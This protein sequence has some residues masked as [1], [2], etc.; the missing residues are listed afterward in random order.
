MRTTYQLRSGKRQ[1]GAREAWSADD[2]V[3]DYVRALGCPHD[4]IVCLGAGAVSWRGA[5]YRAEPA[6][7]ESIESRQLVGTR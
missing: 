6:P 1:I 5:V 4:E 7:D 2:A 3:L